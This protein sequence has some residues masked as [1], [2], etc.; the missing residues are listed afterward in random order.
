MNK[1]KEFV[2]CTEMLLKR[3][4]HGLIVPISIIIIIIIII[5]IIIIIEYGNY[6]SA[7]DDIFS[8]VAASLVWMTSTR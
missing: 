2:Y 1:Q 8:S 6:C 3:I 4:D 7:P 5:S